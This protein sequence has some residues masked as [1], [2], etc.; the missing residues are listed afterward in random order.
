M[1]G[2]CQTELGGHEEPIEQHQQECCDER[3][4]IAQRLC[5]PFTGLMIAE[6]SP[7]ECRNFVGRLLPRMPEPTPAAMETSWRRSAIAR[8]MCGFR[9]GASTSS[10]GRRDRFAHLVSAS[11]RDAGVSP[12][13]AHG[14]RDPR[15][16][17]AAVGCVRLGSLPRSCVTC[18][19]RHLDRRQPRRKRDRCCHAGSD[20]P[21]EPP[22]SSPEMSGPSHGHSRV[23]SLG[24][25][26]M[27]AIHDARRNRVSAAFEMCQPS[28][29]ARI[30][31]RAGCP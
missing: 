19:C 12:R 30:V 2:P 23:V 26:G 25:M 27:V 10:P 24:T 29:R 8:V 17:I 20:Q 15:E 28:D 31:D 21:R 7:A 16:H 9:H 1:A 6:V 5:K 4:G 3:D 14:D 11:A 13:R 18:A 22:R